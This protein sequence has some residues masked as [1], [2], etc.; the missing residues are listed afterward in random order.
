MSKKN[1]FES[2]S[3]KY[4]FGITFLLYL[5]CSMESPEISTKKCLTKDTLNTTAE[6]TKKPTKKITHYQ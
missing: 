6:N 3:V 5:L 2:S 4:F 1:K